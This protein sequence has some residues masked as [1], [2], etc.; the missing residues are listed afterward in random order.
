M[1]FM[2]DP[3]KFSD[4]PPEPTVD[5]SEIIPIVKDGQNSSVTVETLQQLVDVITDHGQ[6]GGLSDDDHPQ[7]ALAAVVVEDNTL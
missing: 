4:F 7:Y 2:L 1:A 5:G 6:L 3:K